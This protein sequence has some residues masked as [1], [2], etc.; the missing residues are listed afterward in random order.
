MNN[1][2]IYQKSDWPKFYWN[3]DKLLNLLSEVRILQG[4]LL[5]YMKSLGFELR[6]EA[7]FETL[8]IDII[9]TTEIEGEILDK[10]QVRSSLAKRLGIEIPNMIYSERHVDGVVDMMLD[11]ISDYNEPLTRERLNNWHSSL[12]PIG[13]SGMHK[14]IVGNLRDDSNGPM[15][16]V[17]GAMGKE[18]VHYQAPNAEEL[19]EELNQFIEWLNNFNEIDPVIKTGIAHLWFITLHPYE[20]GNGRIARAITDMLLTKADGIK[21]RFYSMSSQ[22]RL[23]R[24]E[25]YL[26]LEE[27][28]KGDLDITAWLEW[29]MTCLKR[30]IESSSQILNKVLLKNKFWTKYSTLIKNDR[31][32]V[33]LNKLLDGFEGKLNTSKWAKIAKCSTDTALRDIQDLLDKDILE[34]EVGGGRSTSYKLKELE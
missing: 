11:A 2:Y 12:F 26:K 9:K 16:V 33:L 27:A 17:S 25:Y 3:S 5:G 4:K 18:R 1:N 8:T 24:K 34:K 29:F 6:E 32:K 19:D 7:N 21:Q 23:E 31:Q 30:A 20:D 13:R 10:E 15:Q 28:Q 22:I 14:I